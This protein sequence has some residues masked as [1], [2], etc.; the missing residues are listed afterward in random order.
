MNAREMRARQ[1]VAAENINVCTGYYSV[2]SQYGK[3]RYYVVLDGLF[4]CCTCEDFEKTRKDCKHM[5]AVRQWLEVRRGKAEQP[6]KED[7][8]VPVPR[9]TYPQ[10]DWSKYN[11]T[12][13]S[14]T[15]CIQPTGAAAR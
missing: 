15:F 6:P 8:A 11:L 10:A 7:T 2:A 14:R 4:P 5:L 9:K 3:G 1:I 13:L 12:V